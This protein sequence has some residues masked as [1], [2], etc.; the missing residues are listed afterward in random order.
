MSKKAI[1]FLLWEEGFYPFSMK[2]DLEKAKRKLAEQLKESDID[3][4]TLSIL[5]YSAYFNKYF[6]SICES[7]ESVIRKS[8]LSK[9]QLLE[10]IIADLNRAEIIMT[11]EQDLALKQGD[12]FDNNS[13]AN[14]YI[15]KPEFQ[16]KTESVWGLIDGLIDIAGLNL[17]YLKYLK[18][19]EN[20]VIE[21]QL[22]QVDVVKFLGILGSM[23][24]AIKQSY[25]AVIWKGYEIDSDG[26][27]VRLL[28]NTNHLM[29]ENAAL[30][31]L[32]TNIS[33][34]SEEINFYPEK[35][36][37][38]LKFY[39]ETRRFMEIKSV[40]LLSTGL[41][42][43][44]QQRDRK[45]SRSYINCAAALITYYPFYKST[46]LVHLADL[47][48]LDLVN[49]FSILHDLVIILPRPEYNDTGVL[50]LEKYIRFNPK[51][52]KS[53]LLIHFKTVTKYSDRQ[54]AAF[55]NLLTQKGDKHDL[56]EFAMYEVDD[57][58]FFATSTIARAN[59]LYLVDRWLTAAN[60]DLS[61]R[62]YAF[63]DYITDFLKKE[64]LNNYAKFK[65]IEQKTFSF[66]NRTGV[67]EDEEIDL[68]LKTDSTLIIAEIKCITYPLEPVDHYK[69]FQ[70]IKKAKS[71]IDRKENFLHINWKH[72]ETTL[73]KRDEL[74]IK[75]IIIVNFPHYS[76]REIDGTPICDFYLFLSYF[77]TGKFTRLKLEVGKPMIDNSIL[78]YDSK[79]TFEKNF[80]SFFL[81][82]IPILDVVSRQELQ[83]YEVTASG[84]EPRTTSLRVI[85]NP[86]TV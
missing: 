37:E 28:P 51:I 50:D 58:Y 30:T 36:Q 23:Y 6:K 7:L 71:Q 85:Y 39:R 79:E 68:V 52:R 17:N 13:L 74:E 67:K 44:Y 26:S 32:T 22:S 40:E 38:I 12:A 47:T 5:R 63:E 55:F 62:G 34:A 16:N 81:Q 41:K 77:K 76:G 1:D 20:A 72:F 75:K 86:R 3:S 53:K 2:Y 69:A 56:Y 33:N 59:I 18:Y 24:T 49:L 29:L 78:Y 4:T 10:L 60:S 27:T 80:S 14:T 70:V 42:I 48:I 11:A 46:K 57:Y 45:P 43:N 65:I 66:H 54:L 25:D 9:Q 8:K 31:R 21:D 82:P 19:N 15:T 35:Y 73:G 84:T 83:E 64:K 61:E